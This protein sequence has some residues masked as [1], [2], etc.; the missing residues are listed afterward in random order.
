MVFRDV[1]LYCGKQGRIDA[2]H[3]AFGK[4]DA[5]SGSTLKFNGK[6]EDGQFLAQCTVKGL[7]VLLEQG[8]NL[9]LS[10]C[11]F[12]DSS[13]DG[14]PSSEGAA[15]FRSVD[16]RFVR[17]DFRLPD[18]LVGA[19]RCVFAECTF[20]AR[21]VVSLGEPVAVEDCSFDD[22]SWDSLQVFLGQARFPRERLTVKRA[23]PAEDKQK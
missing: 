17:C 9:F 14:I 16:C 5:R 23:N 10:R 21:R 22:K 8:K 4:G 13:I 11:V 6:A 19:K 2:K 7:R 20:P 15:G 1:P 3:C 12:E 18:T